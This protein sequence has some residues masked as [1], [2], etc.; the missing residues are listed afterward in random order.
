[1]WGRCWWGWACTLDYGGKSWP[2]Q[3]FGNLGVIAISFI[4]LHTAT[5]GCHNLLIQESKPHK[6]APME[7]SALKTVKSI[8]ALNSRSTGSYN[9]SLVTS[10]QALKGHD[11]QNHRSGRY[12][13]GRVPLPILLHQRRRPSY[14]WGN[15]RLLRCTLLMHKPNRNTRPR[16]MSWLPVSWPTFNLPIRDRT[17]DR[18]VQAK[19]VKG[20]LQFPSRLGGIVGNENDF[21][22][23]SLP[24]AINAHPTQIAGPYPS[25]SACWGL[26]ERLL[27][28]AF[29][30]KELRRSPTRKY[31]QSR[32][33]S[34]TLRRIWGKEG[35]LPIKYQAM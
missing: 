29:H 10:F 6:T 17:N 21:L 26:F 11:I 14:P 30:D 15:S 3:V 4:P 33:A 27:L 1:M 12:R 16:V 22:A 19:L 8:G 5:W 7:S 28:P 24:S 2:L 23:C 20:F 31:Q 34:R 9:N 35:P 25:F 18:S 32:R 13:T